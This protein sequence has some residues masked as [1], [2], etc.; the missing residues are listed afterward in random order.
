MKNIHANQV[1][2]GV[3]QK[4]DFTESI[5][6]TAT[7][8]SSDNSSINSN[9]DDGNSSIITTEDRN[10]SNDRPLKRSRDNNYHVNDVPTSP[11]LPVISDYSVHE[12]QHKLYVSKL[13]LLLFHVHPFIK[14][15]SSQTTITTMISN[16]IIFNNRSCQF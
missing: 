2:I 6:S 13:F 1:S 4:R 7:S 5:T 9:V 10:S 3:G 15:R 11:E 16:L 12:N 14:Y 8:R